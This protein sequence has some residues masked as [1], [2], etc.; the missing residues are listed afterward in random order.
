M[1]F[2]PGEFRN[3]RDCTEE[4]HF[5]LKDDARIVL[6]NANESQQIL[7]LQLHEARVMLR[8]LELLIGMCE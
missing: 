8:H 2:S 7:D 3:R 6:W 1:G 5:E 4:V